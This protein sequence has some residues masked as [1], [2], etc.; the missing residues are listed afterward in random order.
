[1]TTGIVTARGH[2]E[3][4]RGGYIL[5]ADKVTYNEKT[6][7]MRAEGHVAFLAPTGEVEFAEQEEVTGDM[8]QAFAENVGIL[9]PDNSRFAAKNAQRYDGRYLVANKGIYTACNV[10]KDDP[11]NPPLWQLKGDTITHDNTEHEIYYHDAT[12]DFAGVPVLYTPYLSMPDP[13]VDRRQGFLAPTPGVNPNGLGNFIR[14]PYYFD[15][16]PDDRHD[17]PFRPSAPKISGKWA[18]KLG[19]VSRTAICSSTAALPMPI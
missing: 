15:I 19:I 3:I 8:K 7:V 10:C 17:D 11:D 14:I 13:T 6:G 9:F 18:A 2:V 12:I 5:H 1:M 16:A 4:A